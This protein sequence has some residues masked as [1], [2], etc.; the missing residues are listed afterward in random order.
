MT[1]NPLVGGD[2]GL[3]LTGPMSV[4]KLYDADL[5]PIDLPALKSNLVSFLAFHLFLFLV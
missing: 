2:D 4:V 5:N 3:G 1:K